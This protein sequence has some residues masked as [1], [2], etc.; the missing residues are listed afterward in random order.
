LSGAASLARGVLILIRGFRRELI[1]R[2][3]GRISPPTAPSSGKISR[4]FPIALPVTA[5]LPPEIQPPTSVGSK[6]R[7]PSLQTAPLKRKTPPQPRETI[8]LTHAAYPTAH[9][10]SPVV[11]PPPP[12]TSPP[13]QRS[14]T[15]EAQS[16]YGF[17]EG[18]AFVRAKPVRAGRYAGEVPKPNE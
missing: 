13:F 3:L 8:H 9:H 14:S 5:S 11:P 6:N 1:R 4:Q 7:P 18:C 12:P 17:M 2:F 10:P 15:P 16:W